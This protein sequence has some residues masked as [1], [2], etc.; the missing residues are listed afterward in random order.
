MLGRPVVLYPYRELN[1]MAEVIALPDY[2]IDNYPVDAIAYWVGVSDLSPRFTYTIGGIAFPRVTEL[3]EDPPQGSIMPI[4]VRTM[5]CVQYLLP[6]QLELI[7]KHAYDLVV[8]MQGRGPKSKRIVLNSKSDEW[9]KQLE[10]MVP[11][12]RK[13]ATDHPVAC[14]VY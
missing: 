4:R 13:D 3:V 9:S 6:H 11:T 7:K 12:Y 10:K 1:Q 5:G 2:D 8:R 14:Y